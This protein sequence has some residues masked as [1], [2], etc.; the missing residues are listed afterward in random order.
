MKKDSH[1]PSTS[2]L[3]LTS[4][5]FSGHLKEILIKFLT[6]ILFFALLNWILTICGWEK[7]PTMVENVYFG[8]KM[9]TVK[10]VEQNLLAE[11]TDNQLTYT[12]D[13]I[14]GY[15]TELEYWFNDKHKLEGVYYKITLP[16]DI[17]EDEISDLYKHLIR[18][19]SKEYGSRETFSDGSNILTR[20]TFEIAMW[21]VDDGSTITLVLFLDDLLIYI[22]HSN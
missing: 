14:Q 9:K 21:D 12:V 10:S 20:D 3:V 17:T 6:V 16:T 11:E 7:T 19:I 2:A 1:L 8:D 13:R 18:R 4:L 22:K 15:D 5:L